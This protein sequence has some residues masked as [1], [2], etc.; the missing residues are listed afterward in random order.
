MYYFV[1]FLK[2][3]SRKEE[4]TF[5]GLCGHQID[6]LLKLYDVYF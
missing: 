5:P 2:Q 6:D 4:K 1:L 3:S